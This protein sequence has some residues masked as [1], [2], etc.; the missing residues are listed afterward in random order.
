MK[1]PSSGIFFDDFRHP[2][3]HYFL[4]HFHQDHL[5]G[6]NRTWRKGRLFASAETRNLLHHITHLK[7]KY[8]TE[9]KPLVPV[10]I[11]DCGINYRITAIPANHCIGALMFLVESKKGKALYTGDFRFDEEFY[12]YKELFQGIDTVYMDTTYFQPKYRFPHQ[13]ESIETVIR[14][15]EEFPQKKMVFGTYSIG[16]E[17]IFIAL[18]KHFG[19]KI[20]APPE[21]LRHYEILG[22]GEVFTKNKEETRFLAYNMPALGYFFQRLASGEFVI[23]I[24]RGFGVDN[25]NSPGKVYY[26]PYSEHSS[27]DEIIRFLNFV[28]PAH[29]YD[30]HGK[31]ITYQPEFI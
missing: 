10:E 15:A 22:L 19:Q 24:P 12:Q 21:K 28:N 17:K 30:L 5:Y 16:K 1:Y 13:R 20:F 3:T 23:I 9:I 27:Y 18:N 31:S 14:I 29:L 2:G 26:I 7:D 4:S 6:L 11:L 8:V 25:K